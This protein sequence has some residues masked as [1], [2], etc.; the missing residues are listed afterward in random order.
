MFILLTIIEGS[1]FLIN[2]TWGLEKSSMTIERNCE[3][4]YDPHKLFRG[5]PGDCFSFCWGN[6]HCFLRTI[7]GPSFVLSCFVDV[8]LV[9]VRQHI[10]FL[11]GSLPSSTYQLSWQSILLCLYP[12]THLHARCQSWNKHKVWESSSLEDCLRNLEFINLFF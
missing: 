7:L 8:A 5:L 4:T 1:F 12:A 10:T 9:R 3:V 6:P 2:I 11:R